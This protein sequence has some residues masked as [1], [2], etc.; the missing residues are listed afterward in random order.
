MEAINDYRWHSSD[1]SFRLGCYQFVAVSLNTDGP[2]HQLLACFS[3]VYTGFKCL[4][5]IGDKG[6]VPSRLHSEYTGLMGFLDL[7]VDVLHNIENF[8]SLNCQLIKQLYSGRRSDIHSDY[9]KEAQVLL[10]VIH[11]TVGFHK[12]RQRAKVGLE[13]L[14]GID[15]YNDVLSGLVQLSSV[16]AGPLAY[17]RQMKRLCRP[18]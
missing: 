13:V 4:C 10:V 15:I 12:H 2:N 3:T 7:H 14:D 6:W 11:R 16:P 9:C 17:S 18:Y 8:R 5:Y 1:Y